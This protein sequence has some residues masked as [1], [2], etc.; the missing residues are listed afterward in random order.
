M[1]GSDTSGLST[2]KKTRASRNELSKSEKKGQI[3]SY[4]DKNG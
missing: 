1:S 4:F 2:P 3:G